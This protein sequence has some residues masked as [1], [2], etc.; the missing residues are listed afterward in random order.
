M[1]TSVLLSGLLCLCLPWLQDQPPAV[2]NGGFETQGVADEPVPGW[3]VEVASGGDAVPRSVVGITS[4]DR[5]TGKACLLLAGDLG[6]RTWLSVRQDLPVRPGAVYRLSAFTKTQG[7][8]REGVQYEGCSLTLT[9]TDAAGDV[10]GRRVILPERPRERWTR[11]NTEI[12][13]PASVRKASLSVQLSM[14]GELWVDDVSLE[15]Y[16]GWELAEPVVLLS[17]GFEDRALTGWQPVSIG[18][19]GRPSRLGVD[20]S[21]GE[22]GGGLL[23]SAEADTEAFFALERRLPALPGE[24]FLLSTRASGEG[25]VP[26]P[27]GAATGLFIELRFLDSAGEALGE[28]RSA[29]PTSG[30]FGFS[31]LALAAVAPEGAAQVLLSAGLRA[32]GRAVLDDLLLAVERA[33]PPPYTGWLTQQG[34]AF[35]LH[36]HPDHPGTRFLKTLV[37]DLERAAASGEASGSGLPGP[38]DLYLHLDSESAQAL[39]GRD[40]P[41]FDPAARAFHAVEVSDVVEALSGS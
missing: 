41:G 3:V 30:T 8:R 20:E 5:R 29:G 10:V 22:R 6:T 31:D 26:G 38:V 21:V 14:T 9:L 34:K 35:T 25:L 11:Q 19:R 27:G 32:P 37:R 24:T 23:L 4:G 2:T 7:V 28:P 1:P 13:A 15:L 12:L 36:I 39:A 17:E 40:V 33:E 18:G 16:G